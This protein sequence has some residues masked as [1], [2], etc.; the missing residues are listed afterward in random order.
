MSGPRFRI[1]SGGLAVLMVFGLLGTTSAMAAASTGAA[2]AT[3]TAKTKTPKAGHRATLLHG[4]RPQVHL[5]AVRAADQRA[6]RAAGPA[7]DGALSSQNESMSI[8]G[9]TKKVKQHKP[10]VR[11]APVSTKKLKNGTSSAA[12]ALPLD[13]QFAGLDEN[14]D[15]LDPLNVGDDYSADT[16]GAVG[17]HYYGE[18]VGSGYGFFDKAN[19]ALVEDDSLLNFFNGTGIG[20]PCEASDDNGYYEPHILYDS[21]SDRWIIMTSASANPDTATAIGPTDECASACPPR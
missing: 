9:H 15:D 7:L 19:G 21:Q 16:D 20:S 2:K 12:T 6:K 1:V 14:N 4:K 5:A 11:V 13:A 18:V 8:T 17:P 3:K 10:T